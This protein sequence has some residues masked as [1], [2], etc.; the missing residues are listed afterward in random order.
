[1]GPGWFCDMLAVQRILCMGVYCG[2]SS[3]QKLCQP[4]LNPGVKGSLLCPLS[5]T[6][7]QG[8]MRILLFASHLPAHVRMLCKWP[9]DPCWQAM[10]LF[11]HALACALI[12]RCLQ[13]P[14]TPL[15]HHRRP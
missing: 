4:T 10:H 2:T 13:V 6:Q 3:P 9:A 14:L 11:G 1:V 15:H 8:H 7:A 5:P 12:W